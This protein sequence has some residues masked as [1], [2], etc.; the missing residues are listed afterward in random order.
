MR[1]LGYRLL[2]ASCL[3]G[4]AWTRAPGAAEQVLRRDAAGLNRRARRYYRRASC[5]VLAIR[6]EVA[7]IDN[8]IPSPNTPKG[9]GSSDRYRAS[10]PFAGRR[11]TRREASSVDPKNLL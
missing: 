4:G 10:S 7:R 2:P 11:R 6:S 3:T 5:P 9:L 1:S 8:F